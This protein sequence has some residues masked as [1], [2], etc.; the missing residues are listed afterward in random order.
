MSPRL[1]L[2]ACLTAALCPAQGD[3][4]FDKATTAPLGGQLKLD[5]SGAP[6]NQTLLFAA[7]LNGGPTPLKLL[8]GGSDTRSIQVGVDLISAW[9]LTATTP[10]GA[11]SFLIGVPNDTALQG[12]PIHT[13]LLTGPGNPNLVDKISNDLVLVAGAHGTVDPLLAK[14]GDGR[15][16][17]GPGRALMSVV[18]IQGSAGEFLIAG[19]GTG[20]ILSAQGLNTSEVFDTRSLQIRAGPNMTVARALHTTT[21]LSNGRVL[22]CGGVDALGATQNTCELYDPNTNTFTATGSMSIARAGHAAALLSDGRVLVA[23]GASNLSDILSA[24]NSFLN[25]AEI[26]N[27]TTGTWS[28]ANSIADKLLAPALTTLPNGRV[29]LSGGAKVNFIFGIPTS[30]TTVSNCQLFDPTNGNWS[31]TG[32]MRQHR[33]VHSLNTILL[34][35]GRVLVTGGVEVNIP[36]L[37]PP[38]TLAGAKATAKAEFYNASS[39]T[40]TALPDLPTASTGH[41]AQQMPNGSVLLT[42]GASGAI[43]AAV[44]HDTVLEFSPATN[45]YVRS[46]K[47]NTARATHGVALLPDGNLVVFG[48]ANSATATAVLDTLEMVHQ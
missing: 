20:N 5:Y 40:W 2:A 8:F 37:P 18:P 31:S 12:L 19:G 39:G 13:Q 29:L 46:F 3:F 11:G 42:G 14:L 1:L 43:D 10:S 48:G 28:A 41:G 30:V 38:T 6:G 17:K 26:Y 23:G 27:P 33:G 21:V 7:S 45:T 36:L 9:V 15:S 47:L 44:S 34:T 16:P 25:T 24:I 4:A 35:D 32:A 22:L